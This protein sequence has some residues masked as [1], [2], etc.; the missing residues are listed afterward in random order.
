MDL[1]LQQ[2]I[3]SKKHTKTACLIKETIKYIYRN[4]FHFNE[5]ILLT[6]FR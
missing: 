3:N 2:I 1:C 6:S 4:T 5:D